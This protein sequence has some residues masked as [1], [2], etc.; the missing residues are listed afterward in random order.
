MLS[1]WLVQI[2]GWPERTASRLAIEFEFGLALLRAADESEG[3]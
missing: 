3:E 2:D 1:R